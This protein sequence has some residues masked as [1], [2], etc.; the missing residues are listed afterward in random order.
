MPGKGVFLANELF[1]DDDLGGALLRE[2]LGLCITAHHNHIDDGISPMEIKG[3]F[4][5]E[6]DVRDDKYHL[7]EI[8]KK[9]TDD[10]SRA[11]QAL[12]QSS[13]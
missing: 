8:K 5:R 3:I 11:L 7:E 12:F 4:V 9:I 2:I 1:T 13:K 10:Q 6:I